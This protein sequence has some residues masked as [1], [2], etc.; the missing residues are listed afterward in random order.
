MIDGKS[1]EFNKS[2]PYQTVST[3]CQVLVFDDVKKNFSFESLFSLITE[4]ITLEY[5][6]Q[7]AIKL[8]IQKSPKILIT[9]NYTVGGIGG[10]FERRKFEIEMS[11]YFNAN[12]TPLDHFGHLLFDEWSETEWSRFDSY[13]VNC[14][15]FYLTNGLVSNEFNN[16]L[17]RKFIK[18]TSFEF[19][20]WTKEKAINKDERIYKAQIFEEF[21]TEFPD[22]RKWLTN[23]KFKKWIESYA[24]FIDSIYS[25]GH[26]QGGRWFEIKTKLEDAPF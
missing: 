16:L 13:M 11:A 24:K 6:G 9:T 19:F 4:G 3:D 21:V 22:Y 5:K 23:K 8:P 12:K 17:V 25:E 15:Q 10:S 14:L 18:E 20:E 2:F 7:D 26:S 1:F